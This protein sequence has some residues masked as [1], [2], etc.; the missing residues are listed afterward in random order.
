MTKLMVNKVVPEPGEKTYN[1]FEMKQNSTDLI[2][3][4]SFYRISDEIVR[5]CFSFSSMNQLEFEY[6][7]AKIKELHPKLKIEVQGQALTLRE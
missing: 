6:S 3:H 2:E 1:L 7:M 4:D 5:L